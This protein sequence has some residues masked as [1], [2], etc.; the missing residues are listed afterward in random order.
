M[1]AVKILLLYNEP[2]SDAAV[3]DQDVIVQR[4]AVAAAL[5][6]LGHEVRFQGCTLQL[7]AVHATLAV[8]PPD[9][10]FNLVES[11]AGTDRL[12]G[13]ATLLLESLRIPFTGAG[14][15]AILASSNKLA[16]KRLLERAG[17]PT[18]ACCGAADEGQPGSGTASHSLSGLNPADF[19]S[20]WIIKPVWEHA[21]LGMD[22]S[23]VVLVHS[24]QELQSA[25]AQRAKQIGRP[26]FAE[27]FIAGREFNLSVLA[28]SAATGGAPQVLPPAEIDFSG[29]PA[30]RE[31]IVGQAAKWDEDSPEYQLTPRRFDFPAADAPL[32][33]ELATLAA[34]CWNLFDMHG[35]ARVD[36]RVD[37][38]GRPWILEINANPCLSPDAGFAAAV[39]Q[40]GLPFT[41]AIERILSDA[42]R[43][44]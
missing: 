34:D 18:A 3:A 38:S 43:H 1:P 21:S 27:A 25:V 16:A 24:R 40:G 31:R 4:D 10:V 19:P 36:F 15:Q 35:Y 26:H 17:L 12:M 20:R 22:D 23:S 6:E 11:L 32:M 37:E 8:N 39:A 7:E 42:V 30:G 28:G 41:Q 44:A 29:L 13:L 2:G 5:R 9:V 14:T 33:A